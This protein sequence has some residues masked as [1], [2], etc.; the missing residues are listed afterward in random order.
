M[1]QDGG[2]LGLMDAELQPDRDSTLVRVKMRFSRINV[3]Q[4]GQMD[5]IK[6][7]A[8]ATLS[9]KKET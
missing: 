7:V 2:V 3:L 9:E 6:R 8:R 1:E 5:E 4:L